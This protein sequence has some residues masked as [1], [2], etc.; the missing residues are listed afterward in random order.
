MVII[1]ETPVR[2]ATQQAI[3]EALTVVST[4]GLEGIRE[5]LLD[6][7]ASVAALRMENDRLKKKVRNQR[8]A[9]RSLHAAYIRVL[10]DRDVALGR[11]QMYATLHRMRGS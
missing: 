11:S 8:Q 1:T 7:A 10:H 4:N 2:E 3:K 6:D 9:N 5:Q